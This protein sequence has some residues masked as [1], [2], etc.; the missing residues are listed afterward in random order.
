[1]RLTVVDMENLV[2]GR[3]AFMEYQ[4]DCILGKALKFWL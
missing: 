2:V 3:K 1:M 4:M